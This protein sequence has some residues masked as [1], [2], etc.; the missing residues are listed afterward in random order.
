MFSH[1]SRVIA[2]F[3][4]IMPAMAALAEQRALLVGVGKYS[5]A[6]TQFAG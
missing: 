2:I 1:I 4:I 5:V 3:L 6:N